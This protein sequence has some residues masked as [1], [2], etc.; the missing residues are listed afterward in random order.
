MKRL[1]VGTLIINLLLTVFILIFK[2][3]IPP[4]IPLYYGLPEGAKQLARSEFIILPPIVSSLIIS[5]N[6]LLGTLLKNEFLL[7][8]LVMTGVVACLFSTIAI[9]KILLLVAVWY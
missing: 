6:Y 4:E 7:R 5:L 8:I 9:V 2:N 1:V 3:H